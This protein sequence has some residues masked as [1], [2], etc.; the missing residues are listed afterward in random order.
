VTLRRQPPQEDALDFARSEIER[1]RPY[2]MSRMPS[3]LLDVL[4]EDEIR[5]LAAYILSGANPDSVEFKQ[6]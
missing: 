3:G 4:S 5:D 6:P 1:R 2:P